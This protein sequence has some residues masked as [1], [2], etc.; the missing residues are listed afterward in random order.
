MKIPMVSTKS[1]TWAWGTNNWKQIKTKISKKYARM[2]EFHEEIGEKGG[3]QRRGWCMDP[4]HVR[5]VY[6][7]H[8]L[9]ASFPT[10][11]APPPNNNFHG[12]L[13]LLPQ[14]LWGEGRRGTGGCHRPQLG[15]WPLVACFFK[16]DPRFASVP[17]S[18][19]PALPLV[20]TGPPNF[21]AHH[22]FVYPPCLGIN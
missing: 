11:P 16:R 12:P 5:I 14:R 6:P 8:L 4:T 21:C 9:M 18:P 2:M 20:W 10:S 13:A 19:M 15:G 7:F 3:S 17:F 1:S 22:N